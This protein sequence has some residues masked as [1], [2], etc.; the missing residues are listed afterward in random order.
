MRERDSP[1]CR[2]ND[3]QMAQTVEEYAKILQKDTTAAVFPGAFRCRGTS[4]QAWLSPELHFLYDRHRPLLNFQITTFTWESKHSTA[5][6][7]AKKKKVHIDMRWYLKKVDWRRRTWADK[8]DE[9][10]QAQCLEEKQWPATTQ[11]IPKRDTH[12]HQHKT[13][14]Y[15]WEREVKKRLRETSQLFP[16]CVWQILKALKRQREAH[17]LHQGSRVTLQWGGHGC[18][19]I[20]WLGLWTFPWGL[21]KH[22]HEGQ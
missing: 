4:L 3:D 10:R 20:T 16:Q 17:T 6:L 11:G 9:T 7:T 22:I 19:L 15:A 12:T 5:R 14:S 18:T 1:N 8:W 21:Y 2:Q 13:S